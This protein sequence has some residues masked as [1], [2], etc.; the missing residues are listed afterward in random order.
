MKYISAHTLTYAPSA[1]YQ[2]NAANILRNNDREN[3]SVFL[4]YISL[5]RNFAA[6]IAFQQNIHSLECNALHFHT[7]YYNLINSELCTFYNALS[8]ES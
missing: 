2:T 7:I 6:Y 4:L 8:I 1:D 3:I 5:Q